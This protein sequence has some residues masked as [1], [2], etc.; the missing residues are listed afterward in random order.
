MALCLAAGLAALLQARWSAVCLASASGHAL[1]P[2]PRRIPGSRTRGCR[3][4]RFADPPRWDPTAPVWTE[5]DLQD[6]EVGPLPGHEHTHT[7]IYLHAFG[8]CGKEYVPPLLDSLSPGFPCPWVPGKGRAPGLRVV[9]PTARRLEQPWGPVET[10]WHAYV[11]ASSN[12]VGDLAPLAE[13]RDR[14]SDLVRSEVARLG[15]AAERLFLGGL[16]QGCTAALDV[17]LR[18]APTQGL[19]GF[20]GSVGF[21]PTDSQGFPGSSKAAENLVSHTEQRRR[22]VWLQC[23]TDDQWVPWP[24][25]AKPSFQ[26]LCQG[27]LPGFNLRTVSGRGHIIDDWEGHLLQEFVQEFA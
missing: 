1:P 5:E 22:P 26:A 14:L 6:A 25:L 23:A 9:L 20:V 4:C 19:G 3:T 13:T 18:E 15:G 11:S 10:S 7:L 2:S 8:R 24:E 27:R 12:R 21:L 17:Y 16:S